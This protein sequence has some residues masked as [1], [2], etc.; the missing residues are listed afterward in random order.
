M[1]N[2]N[3][4]KKIIWQ[5]IFAVLIIVVLFVLLIIQYVQYWSL[6][7][8]ENQLQDQ[9]A[10]LEKEHYIFEQEYNYKSSDEFIE[11][12]AHEILGW[13]KEGESYHKV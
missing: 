12:Y 6:A 7:I 11:D 13:G 10:L 5:T 1:E 4:R 8:K 3:I 9:L 2:R